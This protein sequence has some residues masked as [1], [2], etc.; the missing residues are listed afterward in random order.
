MKTP[1]LTVELIPKTC[2]YSNVRTLLPTRE[3]NRIRKLSYSKANFK[4]E[5][6]NDTGT[7]QG[8]RHDLECHETWEYTKSGVQRLIELVSLCP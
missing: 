6:C 8:Y 1:K 7:N 4:C 3:W 2:Y 5:I